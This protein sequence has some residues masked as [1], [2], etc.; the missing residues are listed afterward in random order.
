MV[1]ST[2]TAPYADFQ[3][4][5]YLAEERCALPFDMAELEA[6]AKAVLSPQAY[7][8]VA[9]GASSGDTVRA[10]AAAFRRWRIVPRMLRDVAERDLSVDLLGARFPSP[11]LLS[12]VGV[13]S[14]VHP[15]GERPRPA[16]RRPVAFPSCFRRFLR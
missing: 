16:P 5:V 11:V 7:S 14:I 9:S 6:R 15:D 2:Q 3:Y 8:Y 10:N 1:V 13:Q 12:P 4:E